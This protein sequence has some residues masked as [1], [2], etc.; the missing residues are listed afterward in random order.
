MIVY[1][2]AKRRLLVSELVDEL[3]TSA[4]PLVARPGSAPLAH[5]ERLD[6]LRQLLVCTGSLE[7]AI[8]DECDSATGSF[9]PSWRGPP[10]RAASNVHARVD[11][12]P[13]RGGGG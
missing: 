2:D 13:T 3:V 1:G 9:D 12:P 8:S 5:L 6:L 10:W 4:E 11:P 7:Q